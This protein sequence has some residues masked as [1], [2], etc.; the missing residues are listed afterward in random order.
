MSY[1]ITALQKVCGN[2]YDSADEV[3]NATYA[4]YI[5]E[6]FPVVNYLDKFVR[7]IDSR[8]EGAL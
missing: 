1:E 6:L 3:F 2:L 5:E 8:S 4:S 7:R